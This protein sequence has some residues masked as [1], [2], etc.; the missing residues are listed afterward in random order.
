MVHETGM[1]FLR[2]SQLRKSL[3]YCCLVT[4]LLLYMDKVKKENCMHTDNTRWIDQVAFT[5]LDVCM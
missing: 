2:A 5:Y 3:I 4:L 1:C